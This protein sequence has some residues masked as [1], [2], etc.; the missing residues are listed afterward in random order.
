[1]VPYPARAEAPIQI[2]DQ[3]QSYTFSQALSFS[4]EAKSVSPIT[5]VILFY[6]QVGERL[7]RRIYPKFSPGTHVRVSYTEELQ[8]GQYPPGIRFRVWWELHTQDGHT[9]KTPTKTFEYTDNNHDWRL[10]QG[11]RVDLYWYGEKEKRAQELLSKAEEVLT[12]LEEE[13]GVAVKERVRIYVY[14]SR[15]DMLP[16][17]SPRSEGYDERVLTLGVVVAKNTLLLL[18]SRS[19]VAQILAHEL[20][21]IVVGMATENPYSDLPR[22]LDEGLAMYAE[23]KLPP[24]NAHALEKAIQEDSLLSIR[25]MSSYSGQASQVDLFY[26][27]AYS[28]VDFL[29]REYG[30]EKMRAFLDVFAQGALQEEALQRVYGFGLDELNARWRASLGLPAERAATAT[31]APKESAAPS[32]RGVCFGSVGSLLLPLFGLIYRQRSQRTPKEGH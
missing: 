16:A 7:V 22:W 26:G 30:R 32:R 3:K 21:H 17:L 20:C 8:R 11:K 19:D 6:G 29:L 25:S 1:M 15:Q 9:L 4:L 14:N 27:E 24:E 28:I 2:L 13:I 31:P 18:G 10:L 5:E 23:G 12:R